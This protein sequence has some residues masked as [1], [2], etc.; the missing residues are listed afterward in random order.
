[1]KKALKF[2]GYTIVTVIA[3]IIVLIVYISLM[4]PSAPSLGDRSAESLQRTQQDTNYY[5]IG[6]N[7]L[8]KSNSGLWEEYVEGEPYERG[9]ITGKLNRELM[10]K[11]EVAFVDR[12]RALVPNQNYLKVLN[13]FTRFFN[14]HLT[15]N[16]PAEYQ[17]EIYGESLSES[18]EFDFISPAYE[19]LLNYHA[20]HDIG[21]MMQNFAL[22]GCTSFAVWDNKTSDSSMLIGRNC[23]FY[24]GDKF[25]EDKLVYFCNPKSGYKFVMVTWGGMMGCLSG[26]N[27]KGLTVTINAAKSDLPTGSATPIS[28]LSREILQ[29]AGTIDEAYALARKRKTFVADAIMIGSAADHKTALIEKSPAKTALYYSGRQFVLCTNHFQSDTFK[30]DKNNIENIAVSASMYRYQRLQALVDST[31]RFNYLSVANLLRDQKGHNGKDIGMGNEKAINQ[32]ICHHSVVFEPEKR[33]IWISTQP[34]QLGA[35][36]CYDL[37]EVFKTAAI[38]K[39]AKELSTPELGIPADTFLNGAQWPGYVKYRQ[40]KD[41]LEHA[42]HTR[43]V[44]PDEAATMQTMIASNPQ[45]WETYDWIGQYYKMKKD[46]STALKYFEI[47]LTKEINDKMEE[48]EIAKSVHEL[49]QNKP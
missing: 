48:Q 6:N 4:T 43:T 19:R 39:G 28:L 15:D 42:I 33:R 32:L 36:V 22:V 12:I 23:D 27:E 1:M 21:H 11:Q 24:V 49:K 16:I 46:N 13:L 35:Y 44:I 26:M 25:A 10:Y 37:N 38:S 20:A 8:R 29:Y 31:D 41:Q 2:L 30:N 14:R 47:A 40:I 3:L 34:Y 18:K 5:R 45:Y 17:Q 9:V 7:W